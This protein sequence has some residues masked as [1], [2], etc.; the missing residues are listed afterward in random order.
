M[1]QKLIMAA[2]LLPLAACGSGSGTNPVNGNTTTDGT[3]TDGSTTDGTAISSDGSLPPGTSSPTANNSIYRYEE[4][5]GSGNGYA[6]GFTYNSADDTFTVDNL[7]FDGDNTYTR[8]DQVGSLGAYAVYENASNFTDTT[9]GASIG[10]ISHKVLYGVSKNKTSDGTKAATEFAIVRTGGYVGYGFGGFVYQRNGGVTL[11][12]TGQATYS[13]EYAALRDF[14]NQGGIEYA[15]GDMR[16]SIDFED[17]DAGDAVS[18]TVYNRRIF[19]VNGNDITNQML[20]AMA[21]EYGGTFTTLPTLNFSIGTGSM[22]ANGEMSGSLNSYVSNNG[23]LE[24]FES[25]S[26]YALVSGDSADEIVGVIVVEAT[27]PRADSVTVRETGG[28]VL[29]RP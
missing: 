10:Q 27:D 22:D 16:I 12:G 25:G 6:T 29:Y 20:T 4:D 3:T 21:A 13:G 18:G 28:F 19:D 9:T 1:G 11:P 2:L 14:E 24:T 26:Y 15:T 8:D 17:F 5:D 23:A 7:A